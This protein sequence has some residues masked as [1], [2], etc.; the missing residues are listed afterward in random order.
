[1]SVIIRELVVVAQLTDGKFQ[2]VSNSPEA[3]KQN[4]APPIDEET[5]LKI[6]AEA[7]QQVMDIMERKNDR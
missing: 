7:V 2:S 6:I 5:R 4:Q 1:M 3:S